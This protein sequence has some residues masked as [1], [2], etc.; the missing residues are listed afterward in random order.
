MFNDESLSIEKWK[1]IFDK[2]SYSDESSTYGF[3]IEENSKAVGY[4]GLIKSRRLI[5]GEL[6]SFH[7]IT[8]LITLPKYRNYSLKM[9]GKVFK[10]KNTTITSFTPNSIAFELYKALGMK[11][12]ER[13]QILVLPLFRLF[14][15]GK[16]FF[17]K[18]EIKSQLVEK[19]ANILMDHY[20]ANCLHYGF[21]TL[22][23]KYIYC[24]FKKTKRKGLPFLDLHYSNDYDLVAKHIYSFAFRICFKFR[25]IAIILEKRFFERRIDCS[26]NFSIKSKECR[27]YKSSDLSPK[28]IDLLYSELQ[29][30]H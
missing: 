14:T 12:L 13:N 8:S 11:E 23:N 1:V 26:F 21:K 16:H 22:N 20:N 28:D 10:V 5:N 6:R 3:F 15:H 27:L 19:E 4:V 17:K 9:L 24:I 2:I 30:L 18:D 7:N 25:A 29:F